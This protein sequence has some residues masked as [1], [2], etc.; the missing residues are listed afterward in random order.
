MLFRAGRNLIRGLI[1][2][3]CVGLQS[4]EDAAAADIPYPVKAPAVVDVPPS[5]DGFYLGGQV[6]YGMDSVGWRNLGSSALFS[7]L[8]SLTRD[9]GG[10]VIGGGQVGYNFQFNRIVFGLEGSISA[11]DF[12]RSFAS[13]YF[14]ATDVWSSKITWLSTVTGRIGYGFDSWLPYIKGG[15]AV[16]NVDTSI[17]NTA[18][19]AFSQSSAVHS[20]WALGGGAEFKIAPKFSLGLEFMHTDLGRSND[21]NGASTLGTAENYGVAARSNSFMARFNYLFGR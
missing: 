20:G 4:T 8:N 9:R 10:G 18:A 21:I 19:G 7:P 2:I 17:Q 5:W 3:A 12:D 15:L 14:P 13:P 6:G 11:A 16:A 1:L